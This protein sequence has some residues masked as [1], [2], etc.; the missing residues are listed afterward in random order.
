MGYYWLNLHSFVKAIEIFRDKQ[1]Q[2]K[3]AGGNVTTAIVNMA[4]D[5]YKKDPF[6]SS[7]ERICQLDK[8]I[9]VCACCHVRASSEPAFSLQTLWEH[10]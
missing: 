10:L 5:E 2:L 7:I 1:D 8:A 9:L 3:L 4:V 6:R